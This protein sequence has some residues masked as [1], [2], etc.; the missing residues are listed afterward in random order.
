VLQTFIRSEWKESPK[1]EVDIKMLTQAMGEA[2]I[3]RYFPYKGTMLEN[4]LAYGL[5]KGDAVPYARTRHEVNTFPIQI[6]SIGLPKGAKCDSTPHVFAMKS[7]EI[8]VME[9]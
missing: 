1:D 2:H 3:R 5:K 4:C 8:Q 9:V 6:L 7:S